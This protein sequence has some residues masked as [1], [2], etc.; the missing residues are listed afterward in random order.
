MQNIFDLCRR[1]VVDERLT[2]ALLGFILA[3]GVGFL[4]VAMVGLPC[5]A[6]IDD[7]LVSISVDKRL[8]AVRIYG[9]ADSLRQL[10]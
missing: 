10:D 7:Q 1:I 5:G 4:H 3:R 6:L 2:L 8:S 9:L